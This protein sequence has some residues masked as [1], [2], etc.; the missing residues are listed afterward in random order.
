MGVVGLVVRAGEGDVEGLG[1][2]VAEIVAGA[3]LK[4]LPVV[5]HALHA[6]GVLRTGELLLLGLAALGH[7]HSQVV[8]AEIGV[9]VQNPDRLLH[10]LLCGGVHGVALLPQE[11]PVA[12]EGT[13]GLFPAQ[14]AA[15]LIVQLGQ[16][17]VGVDDI[18]IVLA[19]QRLTGGPDAVA[20]LQLLAAAAGD[21]G[22]LGSE[23]LHVV[24][25]LLQQA[26]GNQHGHRHV[27]MAGGLKLTVQLLL[28]VFPDGIA[29]RAVDEHALDA[30]II[31]ELRLFANIGEP[32]G[33]V[34]VPGGDGVHLSLILSHSCFLLNLFEFKVYPLVFYCS[35]IGRNCQ[36][37]IPAIA[38]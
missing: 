8:L 28:H 34:H 21:P 31:N 32:L 33:E 4:G 30:G 10:S 36:E 17:P 16:V 25:L 5:H 6:V 15:P 27:F 1:K 26:L 2:A 23:A 14:D 22:A 38:Q 37:S 9:E 24:L 7:G 29:V 11:F 20:L 19:E 35:G 3:R 13:A 12:E 18:F